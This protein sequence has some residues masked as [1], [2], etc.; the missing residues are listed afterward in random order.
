MMNVNLVRIT[1]ALAF[2]SFSCFAKERSYAKP[3]SS[4]GL[5]I[6][7][8]QQNCVD[9]ATVHSAINVIRESLPYVFKTISKDMG[10]KGQS[11][12]NLVSEPNDTILTVSPETG[13]SKVNVLAIGSK[14]RE[15]RIRREILRAFAFSFGAGASQFPGNIMSACDLD[16]IDNAEDFLPFDTIQTISRVAEKRGLKPEVLADYAT[17]CQEGWAPNPSTPEEQKIWDEVHEI[18]TEPI[19]ITFDPTTDRK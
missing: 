1:F 2:V 19:R 14:N 7:V 16:E 9:E 5:V 3:N 10:E 17:A 15:A 6:I 11:V 18:P 12:I 4:S 8:N 13:I